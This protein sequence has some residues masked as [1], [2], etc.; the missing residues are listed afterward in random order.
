MKISLIGL[1]RV[2]AAV[3]YILTLYE[4][5]DEL[6]IV[7]RTREKAEAFGEQVLDWPGSNI[8][9]RGYGLIVNTSA[10]GM[11][12]Q[13]P[14]TLTHLDPDTLVSDL[15][16]SPLETQLLAS[17]RALGGGPIDGLGMLLHQAAGGFE[18]W[19][20]VRPEV[21]N[22]RRQAVRAA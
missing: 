13:N 9:G 21:T 1:G 19:F 3:G 12:G 10:C 2:G 16:Y 11:N 4:Q 17:A 15:V 8:D 18:K 14:L 7:N 5:C 22:G 20:G 6:V